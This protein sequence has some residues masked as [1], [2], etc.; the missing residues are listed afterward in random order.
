MT[1]MKT[2]ATALMASTLLVAPALAQSNPPPAA[3]PRRPML[4]A[5][6]DAGDEPGFKA[7]SG[8]PPSSSA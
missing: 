4:R 3:T 6:T 5:A 7:T 2:F 8:A 1:M